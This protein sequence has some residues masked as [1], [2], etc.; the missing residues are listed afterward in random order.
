VQLTLVQL[1]PFFVVYGFGFF[2]SRH[3]IYGWLFNHVWNHTRVDEHRFQANLDPGKW[4][5][6]QLT[7]LGAILVSAGMLYPWAVI[8]AQRYAAS[9]LQF[10][11]AGPVD[12]IQRIGGTKGSA[13]GDMAAE[14]VG[15]DFGL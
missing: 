12:T 10:T 6:L 15:L 7:N 2:L 8:R 13:T 3:F 14:F 1:I 9:C 4:L 11:P 5:G